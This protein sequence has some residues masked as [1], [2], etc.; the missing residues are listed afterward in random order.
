MLLLKSH[1]EAGKL[2]ENRVRGAKK[3]P[4]DPL[5]VSTESGILVSYPVSDP[6]P[7][8]EGFLNLSKP[9]PVDSCCL[10][11]ADDPPFPAFETLS[12]SLLSFCLL[13]L[14]GLL[15]LNCQ[16]HSAITLERTLAS[17]WRNCFLSKGS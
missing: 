9:H 3:L 6:F 1:G 15:W 2:V 4:R 5:G 8:Q 17:S 7:L 11:S 16:A 14:T 12:V 13:Y 10:S